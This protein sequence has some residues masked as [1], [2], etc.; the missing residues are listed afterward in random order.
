MKT[1]LL[2][3][4]ILSCGKPFAQV[5][6]SNTKWSEETSQ[7]FSSWISSDAY[8][9][10]IFQSP[11][12]PWY[13]IR[14]DCADAI[15]A[16]Q[17]I[18]A[19]ETKTEF[20]LKLDSSNRNNLTNKTT[21]FD[22][23]SDPIQRVKA[24]I[25]LIGDTIGTEGLARFNSYPINPGQLRPG[26]FYVARWETNGEFVRHA[27]M[28]KEIL[29]TGHLVLYSSTT[30]VKVR[31]LET[32][33]GMPLH[34]LSGQPWGFKRVQPFLGKSS[35]L[36]DYSLSQYELLDTAG[37]DYFFPRVLDLLKVREDTLEENLLRR[38]KNLCSQLKL[39]KKEVYATQNYLASINNRCMNYSEYDEHSTP[40]RDKSLLNGIK[41][42]LYGWKKIRQS[43][44]S[45]E[46]SSTLRNGLDSL[47]RKNQS[48]Q[49]RDDLKNLCQIQLNL[50]NQEVSYDLKNFFD[51][52][53]KQRISSHPNDSLDMRWGAP[54]QKTSCKSFY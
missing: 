46:L 33:E 19:F 4:F 29:P 5:W 25:H 13:G 45:G 15:I 47:L 8:S 22:S 48:E 2:I 24:F 31:E 27:S 30:P 44:S 38:V 12:S 26:D 17:V 36:E 18:Y 7:D 50:N 53:L 10:A 6:D 9:T 51:L 37:S 54:G 16:A 42:L 1:L 43:E 28:I 41:R 39:R 49:A 35:E 11:S 40:S 32:R 14:T 52:S 21:Q 23:I 20:T 3:I 34:I